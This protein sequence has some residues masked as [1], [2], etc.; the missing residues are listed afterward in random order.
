MHT[1]WSWAKYTPLVKLLNQEI[2]SL[3]G[4]E[5]QSLLRQ[6][7]RKPFSI[8]EPAQA[9]LPKFILV[10]AN[11][12][13]YSWKPSLSSALHEATFIHRPFLQCR[14]ILK[15]TKSY[16][17]S[18]E[19][20]RAPGVIMLTNSCKWLRHQ[21]SRKSSRYAYVLAGHLAVTKNLDPS[22]SLLIL[23]PQSGLSSKPERYCKSPAKRP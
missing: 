2:R 17:L 11:V 8:S 12:N 21:S 5:S 15:E 1:P 7:C 9:K 3:G 19:V 20:A 22:V 4:S 10:W 13:S 23:T 14:N 16:G 6:K 18:L